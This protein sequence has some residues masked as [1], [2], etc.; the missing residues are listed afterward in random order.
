MKQ[1]WVDF[2]FFPFMLFGTIFVLYFDMPLLRHS[3]KPPGYLCSLRFCVFLTERDLL[4]FFFPAGKRQFKLVC[5][6][7][8]TKV[9]PI[10]LCGFPFYHDIE[11][12]LMG[13]EKKKKINALCIRLLNTVE[14]VDTQCSST[15][16]FITL[17]QFL[18]FLSCRSTGTVTSSF[19]PLLAQEVE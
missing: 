4:T 11:E 15:T 19:K 14:E 16:I 18:A 12:Y 13:E 8:D 9:I 10:P 2:F 3:T 17:S 6:L 5:Q 7:H 1:V